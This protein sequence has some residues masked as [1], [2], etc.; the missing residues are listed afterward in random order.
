MYETKIK[1]LQP[2]LV[3]VTRSPIVKNILEQILGIAFCTLNDS[4]K[5]QMS[6]C[7]GD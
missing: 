7:C 5:Q 1:D 4:E 6:K 2:R 3:S